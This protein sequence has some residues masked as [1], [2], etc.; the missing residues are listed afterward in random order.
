MNH[1]QRLAQN[2][3]DIAAIVEHLEGM[4]EGTDREENA[5]HAMALKKARRMLQVAEQM[6]AT[7]ISTYSEA[8]LLSMGI[9]RVA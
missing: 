3:A 1:L 8:E 6:W 2:R 9:V 7:A 5:A 4:A